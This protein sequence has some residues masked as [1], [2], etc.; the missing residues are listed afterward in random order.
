MKTF[1]DCIPCIVRQTLDSVRLVAS[2]EALHEQVLREV[3]RAAAKMDL[4][5]TPPQMA[6]WIH[7]RI[8]EFV[9]QN[10]PY[11]QIKDQFNRM[12]LE[13]YPTL[14]EWVEKSDNQVETSVSTRR[15]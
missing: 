11:R 7:R 8:R 3:L 6:Q 1:L 15:T 10:D 2:D 13:L 4:H 14:Q 5:Q 12:A 9:G